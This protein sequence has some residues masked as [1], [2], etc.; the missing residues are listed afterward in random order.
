MQSDM[1]FKQGSADDSTHPHLLQYLW[2]LYVKHLE[3][4]LE[5]KQRQHVKVVDIETAQ[6]KAPARDFVQWASNY[7]D[8]NR[9]ISG[10]F[11]DGNHGI[12]FSDSSRVVVCPT[13]GDK[14]HGTMQDSNAVS[15][16]TS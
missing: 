11:V 2:D 1:I 4:M 6:K 10:F 3:E 16:T 15:I 13:S 9:A 7:L 8:N 14:L 5:E 12:K